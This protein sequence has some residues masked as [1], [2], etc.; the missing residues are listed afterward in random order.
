MGSC[1]TP[2]HSNRLIYSYPTLLLTPLAV[3]GCSYTLF[4]QIVRISEIKIAFI[5]SICPLPLLSVEMVISFMAQKE[6]A[7]QGHTVSFVGIMPMLNE[8]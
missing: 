2:G 1:L 6:Q 3:S 8:F 4:R 5:C 7:V